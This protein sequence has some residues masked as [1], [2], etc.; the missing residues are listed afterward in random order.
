MHTDT[1][2]Y[3]R[4]CQALKAVYGPPTRSRV[5]YAAQMARSSSKTRHPYSADGLSTSKPSTVQITQFRTQQSSASP[6]YRL[7]RSL[8]NHSLSRRL[9]KPYTSSKVAKQQELMAF[10]PRSGNMEVLHYIV[11]SLNCWEQGKL[12]QDLHDTV[13]IASYKN[14]GEKSDCSNYWGSPSV[15]HW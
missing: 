12:R 1:G 6:N 10:H 11:S 2:D 7:K 3:S 13:L 5:H 8:T 15:H 4:F 9:S 14:K